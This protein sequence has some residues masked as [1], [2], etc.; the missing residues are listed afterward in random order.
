MPDCST[1]EET[2]EG[3]RAKQATPAL[4]VT[5]YPVPDCWTVE[6][7]IGVELDVL[8]HQHDLENT[9]TL[10]ERTRLHC[11]W[12]LTSFKSKTRRVQITR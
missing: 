5:D 3:P 10:T 11:F 7:R 9:L 1:V 12:S 6:E 4:E 2:D 8:L